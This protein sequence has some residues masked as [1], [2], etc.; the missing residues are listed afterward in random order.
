MLWKVIGGLLL[1]WLVISVAGFVIKGLFWL[2]V[3]GGVL[4]VATAAI[5]WARDRK[6]IKP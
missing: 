2:A 3:I 6:Q 5:G 4:F 1:L